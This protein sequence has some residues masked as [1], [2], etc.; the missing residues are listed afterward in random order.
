MRHGTKARGER[1]RSKLTEAD[2]MEIRRLREEGQSMRRISVRFGV[3]ESNVR[4]ILRG[5]TWK[6]LLPHD[7][8][9]PLD[10]DAVENR[11]VA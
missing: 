2:V 7:E 10:A 3:S 4:S 5:R 9:R 8:A 6:H 11:G 1:L